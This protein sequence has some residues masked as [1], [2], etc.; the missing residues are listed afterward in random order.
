MIHILCVALTVGLMMAGCGRA[1]NA[2]LV[3][4]D[5]LIVQNP[6]S[7][8]QLLAA[9]P[10]DSLT[11]DEDRA[12]HALLTTIADYKAYHPI[13]SD[14][15]INIAITHYDHDGTN[16]DKRMRSL[17]YKGAIMN[18]LGN[19]K[20]AMTY[21]KMA[22]YA[23]PESD[24][25]HKGYIYYRIAF[26]YQQSE[27]ATQAL[28][29]YRRALVA[30]Q[31]DNNAYYQL[32]CEKYLGALYQLSNP[33]SAYHYI[34]RTI[35]DAKLY[36]E[37]E[38]LYEALVNSAGYYFLKKDFGK[39]KQL[40]MD[41]ILKGKDFLKDK[42]AYYFA[43]LSYLELG[44]TDSAQYIQSI[45]PVPVTLVDSMQYYRCKAEISQKISPKEIVVEQMNFADTLDDKIAEQSINNGLVAIDKSIDND[46]E[47]E[48]NNRYLMWTAIVVLL[49]LMVILYFIFKIRRNKQFVA[50]LQYEVDSLKQQMGTSFEEIE[51]LKQKGE[52]DSK[53]REQII[54]SIDTSLECY[55]EVMANLL[56]HY[57]TTSSAKSKKI[58][59]MFD[60]EFFSRLHHYVNMR[61]NNLVEKLLN[62]DFKLKQEEIN[63]IC[64]ELCKFPNAI[65]WVYSNCD[66]PRSIH[67]KKKIIAAKVNHSN[68]IT[69]ILKNV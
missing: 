46:H 20:E 16:P 45:T 40:S 60:D 26:L 63:I 1:D 67:L 8:Y 68:S 11:S 19:Y 24:F 52:A 17:L 35:T 6:D 5:S 51:S 18:E 41:V 61:Y 33:D 47:K 39:S 36:C 50:K 28:A 56:Q 64:L 57:K 31:T 23:C 49:G 43:C 42:Y 4:I 14:S 7:A 25:F 69:D 12:Y 15:L 58:H 48:K 34:S 44:K 53:Q 29:Y 21:Y 3:A 37:D 54:S 59:Q 27:E 38:I 62:S 55:S 66:R 9:M 2:S 22:Q 10:A 30:F 65:I 32:Q 13:T